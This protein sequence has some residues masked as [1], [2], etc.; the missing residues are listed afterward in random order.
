MERQKGIGLMSEHEQLFILI[1]D[2]HLKGEEY[3]RVEIT[4]WKSERSKAAREEVISY[5]PLTDHCS[6]ATH[7]KGGT[8]L[9]WITSQEV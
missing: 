3:I 8:L 2:S 1:N 9:P 5:Q 7:S 4:G 6:L